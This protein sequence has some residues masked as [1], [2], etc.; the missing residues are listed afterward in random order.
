MRNYKQVFLHTG[1]NLGKRAKNLQLAN[2]LIEKEIGII[3]KA[4]KVYNTR[5]WGISDQPDFL[6][7]ALEVRTPLPPM[8]ILRKIIQIE[9]EMG[10]TR[11]FKWRERIID[12]DILFYEDEMIDIPGLIIPHPYL[13]YRNFVLIPLIDIAPDLLHPRLKHTIKELYSRSEDHLK[14]EAVGG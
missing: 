5:A 3:V 2:E 8:P 12:I 10:R 1:T 9:K 11:E 6:N 13:H 7:Q 4:S 14:V